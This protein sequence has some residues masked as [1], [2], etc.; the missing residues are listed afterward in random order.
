MYIIE[1]LLG[2]FMGSGGLLGTIMSG[3]NS[4]TLLFLGASSPGVFS[5]GH[6]WGPFTATLLHGGLMHIGFNLFALYQIG[7]LLEQATTKSFFLFTYILTGICG[8]LLSASMGYL[9]VGASAA[10]YGLI[11]CG[12]SISFI[13]GQ[14][15]DDPLFRGLVTW[16][17]YGVIFAFLMPGIDHYAHLGGLIGGLGL[18]FIW[19]KLRMAVWFRGFTEKVS[20]IMVLATFIG[21]IH[22]G[23]NFYK[24]FF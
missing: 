19:T 7:P 24:Y 17:I 18:G 3:P 1:V 5:H 8:F 14:G 10:L 13:L 15:K 12:I 16:L 21:L 2:T 23:L 6:W 4:K 11:G 20:L 9:S 22:S